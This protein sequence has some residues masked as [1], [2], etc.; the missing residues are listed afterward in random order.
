MSATTRQ[1]LVMHTHATP[2]PLGSG[3]MPGICQVKVHSPSCSRQK[4]A[5][6]VGTCPLSWE[7]GMLTGAHQ[8]SL[9]QM[10]RTSGAR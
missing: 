4:K 6:A 5:G 1:V 7:N 10:R 8:S 2:A 9:G 3:N